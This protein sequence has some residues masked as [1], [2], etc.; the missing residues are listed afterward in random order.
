MP[1]APTTIKILLSICFLTWPLY[2]LLSQSGLKVNVG[3]LY[4]FNIE[5]PHLQEDEIFTKGIGYFAHVDYIYQKENWI[6]EPGI[7]GGVKQVFAN[8]SVGRYDFTSESTKLIALIYCN[9][10]LSEHWRIGLLTLGE[11]NKDFVD[12]KRKSNDQYRFNGGLQVIYQQ[13]KLGVFIRYT[14]SLYPNVNIYLIKNP[15][16]QLSFGVSYKIWNL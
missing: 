15:S 11:N 2:E 6:I 5:N 12:F 7:G 10:L 8:G 13:N 4:A 1:Y 14:R 9:F 3:P 16:D